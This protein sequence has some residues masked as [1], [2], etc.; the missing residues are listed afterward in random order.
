MRTIGLLNTAIRTFNQGDFIIVESVR[1]EMKQVLDNSFVVEL[2]THAP[3]FRRSEFGVRPSRNADYCGLTGLDFSLL[4]GTNLIAGSVTHRWNQWNV[5]KSDAKIMRNVVAIGVG[6]APNFIEPK[7]SARSL[8][9]KIFS[10]AY[11]H[12]ARDERTATILRRCGLKAVNTGC[13]TMWSL[14]KKHC[15]TIPAAKAEIV[16]ATITDYKQ[17]PEADARFLKFLIK[18]YRVV[19]LWIQGIG[20]LQYVSSLGILDAVSIIPP[21]LDAYDAFLK[22]HECDYV[23]TRLHAG[24]KAMQ[25]GRRAIILGVDNRSSDIAGTHDINYVAREDFD[26]LFAKVEGSFETNVKIDEDAIAL[27]KEQFRG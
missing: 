14:T 1:R 6:S 22:E 26:A 9:E 11:I 27:F 25:R 24:I 21:N 19:Y 16:V 10:H 20:D 23:G 13:A 17:D 15:S 12:S 18:S 4:C 7:R 2:P 5:R 3:V 8:Y